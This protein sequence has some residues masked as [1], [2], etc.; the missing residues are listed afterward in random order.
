MQRTMTATKVDGGYIVKVRSDCPVVVDGARVVDVPY[1]GK[2]VHV[3]SLESVKL[4]TSSRVKCGYAP[5]EDGVVPLTVDEYERQLRDLD[6]RVP[7]ETI[8]DEWVWPDLD[9]EFAYRRF[10]ASYSLQTRQEHTEHEIEWSIVHYP[11]TG[12][13]FLVPVAQMGGEFSDAQ[14]VYQRKAFM[15]H[16]LRGAMAE[17]GVK[18]AENAFD[19]PPGTLKIYVFRDGE[20]SVHGKDFHQKW[21]CRTWRGSLEG[22]RTAMKD[23]RQGVRDAVALVARGGELSDLSALKLRSRLRTLETSL[24]KVNPKK[25]GYND[26][27]SACRQVSSLIR[28]IEAQVTS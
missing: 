7:H 19:Q 15:L 27:R 21:S 20:I 24:G 25:A 5:T 26:W 3:S 13:K 9:A 14:V 12:S 2:D 8:E 17:M 22:A 1:G 28:D 4:R 23:D 10:V 16:E 18:E 6:K 11:E